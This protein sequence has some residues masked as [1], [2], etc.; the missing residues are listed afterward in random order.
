MNAL[1]LWTPTDWAE[2]V[3][4]N[5]PFDFVNVIEDVHIERLIQNKFPGLRRDFTK[6]YDELDDQDFFGIVD[7][8]LSELSFIDRINLHFKLGVVLLFLSLKRR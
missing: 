4:N 2:K 3:P 5:I 1:L 7:K 6:G 8:D